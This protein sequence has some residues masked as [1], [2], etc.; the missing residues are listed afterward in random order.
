[1]TD[2]IGVTE[3][4]ESTRVALTLRTIGSHALT[5]HRVVLRDQSFILISRKDFH[6][7]LFSYLID[8]YNHNPECEQP[9]EKESNDGDRALGHS[10]RVY[11]I[12]VTAA[13]LIF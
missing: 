2:Q 6:S 8:Q 1:M 7:S 5:I 9:Q 13:V 4:H 12:S 3:G 11:A 10:P